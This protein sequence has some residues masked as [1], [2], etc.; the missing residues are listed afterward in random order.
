MHE[1]AHVIAVPD[2]QGL[3]APGGVE[4]PLRQ[5]VVGD[6]LTGKDQR[7][8]VAVAVGGGQ[9]QITDGGDIDAKATG[10][11]AGIDGMGFLCTG[12]W[13]IDIH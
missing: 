12:G 5:L 9:Q 3:K 2:A 13:G 8:L 4:C 7:R 6:R 11:L 1:N 10:I